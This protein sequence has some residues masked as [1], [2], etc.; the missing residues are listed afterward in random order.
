MPQIF[1]RTILKFSTLRACDTEELRQRGAGVGRGHQR[2]TNEEGVE[3]GAAE[4][5][6]VG[7]GREAGFGHGDAVVGDLIDEFEG[8]FEADFERFEVAVIDADDFGAG[9]EG[10]VEFGFSVHFDERFHF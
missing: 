5:D 8:G 4:T 10:A 3:A 7:V 2:F 1:T 9:G 6:K